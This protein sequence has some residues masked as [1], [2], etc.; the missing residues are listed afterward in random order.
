MSLAYELRA[1]RAKLVRLLDVYAG[2]ARS[3]VPLDQ[4]YPPP[5]ACVTSLQALLAGKV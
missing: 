1:I 4:W 5:H 3:P 2:I